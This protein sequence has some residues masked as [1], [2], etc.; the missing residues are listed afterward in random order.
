MGDINLKK[1]GPVLLYLN[2]SGFDSNFMF[3][4]C[5]TTI[6]YLKTT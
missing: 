2:I 5:S 3:D 1:N 4:G 6:R